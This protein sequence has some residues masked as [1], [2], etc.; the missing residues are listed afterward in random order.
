MLH[1]GLK[2]IFKSTP[3]YQSFL[4]KNQYF[5]KKNL[6]LDRINFDTNDLPVNF[7]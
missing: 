5:K 1:V 3:T 2:D 4:V 6:F 7:C